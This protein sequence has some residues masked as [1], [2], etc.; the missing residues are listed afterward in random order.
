MF[1]KSLRPKP[2]EGSIM[3]RHAWKAAILA[4]VLAATALA[5]TVL[6]KGDTEQGQTVRGGGTSLVSGGTGA[7]SFVPVLT[8]F[9]FNSR[10]G[11]GR[12]ECLA[13]APSAAAGAPGS[14]NFDTNVMYVTGTITSA[15]VSGQT[16][17]LK[18][19]ASVTGAGAGTNQA[20]TLTVTAGGPGSTLVLQ[21][22]GLT[23]NEIVL[24]GD[25]K[26]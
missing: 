2:E 26:L 9:A 7:P 14:G 25:I 4:L 12:F 1:V 5:S 10:N 16:A 24:E 19:S 13:L 23:F 21:V 6:A 20:F 8:K 22:S 15:E 3:F 17:V 18:G 11:S